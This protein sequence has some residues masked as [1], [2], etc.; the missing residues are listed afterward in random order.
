MSFQQ[1]ITF[2][3]RKYYV[4][5]TATLLLLISIFSIK[6]YK[7]KDQKKYSTL[8]NISG[9]QRMLSQRLVHLSY[10][11]IS[12]QDI[13]SYNS[14]KN[15]LKLFS[16]SHDEIIGIKKNKNLPK[17]K[18][19]ILKEIYENPT[20]H[21]NREVLLYKEHVETILNN[22]RLHLE[23][24]RESVLV[25]DKHS[26]TILF[27][28]DHAVQ[29]F[30]KINKKDL[31]RSNKLQFLSFLFIV[32]LLIFQAYKVFLPIIS[33]L[34][35]SYNILIEKSRE[36]MRLA[37]VKSEFLSNMSHELR[38]PMNGML[39]MLDLLDDTN[40]NN[41]QKDM[42]NTVRSSGTSLLTVLND[43]LDFSK[44][45]QNTLVLES[46]Q[47]DIKKIMKNVYDTIEVNCTD[48]DID[49]NLT[50]DDSVA[51][52]I[53]GDE[54]RIEQ[55][56]NNFA[57]NAIKFT[58]KGQI[59]L[60]VK[61]HHE[62]IEFKVKD[63]GKGIDKSYQNKLFN[64]FSQEDNSMTRVYGGIGLGLSI[65][66][67]LARLMSGEIKLISEVDKGT[68]ISLFIP[69][70]EKEY[71]EPTHIESSKLYDLATDHPRNILVAE[72]NKVNQKLIKLILKKL[73]YNPILVNNG[74]EAYDELLKND[75]DIVFMDI[76]MPVLDG[77]SATK[78]ILEQEKLKDLTIIAITAN[79]FDEDRENCKLAGMKDF[80]PKPIK[81]DSIIEIIKKY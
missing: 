58:I 6:A 21:L 16:E 19:K 52:Y 8:I 41:D 49:V 36:T 48:K 18:S 47:V 59:T 33:K 32:I 64:A 4:A 43:I 17:I 46:S 71:L 34:F 65:S 77:I 69:Y 11:L 23:K 73:G 62:M 67:K 60:S 28:L 75:Y 20:S 2:Y 10:G 53:E 45:E 26:S 61:K 12:K 22:Y 38:T 37:Q 80:I 31:S 50:I 79:A 27:K 74:L 57:S 15:T 29:R 24:A 70:K 72:D 35:A 3:K 54:A 7:N 55:I 13:E 76:Q 66:I 14:L 68:E 39:G 44:L 1:E 63:T 9:R 30:E 78:K 5:F 56:I 40:L 42:I 81:I 25:I 51:S